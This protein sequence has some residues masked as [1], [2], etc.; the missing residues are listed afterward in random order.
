MTRQP[1]RRTG[2]ALGSLAATMMALAGCADVSDTGARTPTTGSESGSAAISES[3][4]ATTT[5]V[6]PTATDEP[7]P[8]QA[9]GSPSAPS[10]SKTTELPST[11]SLPAPST[12]ATPPPGQGGDSRPERARKSRIPA[13]ALPGFNDE[14]VWQ[15]A[16]SGPG[17]GQHLPGLCLQS[18]LTAIGAVA[19]HRTDFVSDLADTEAAVQ[20]TAVLP[21]EQTARTASDVLLTWQ[22]DCA[23][24]ARSGLGLKRVKVG[25]PAETPTDVGVGVH[26]LSTYGPVE[27][28]P[29]AAWFV[30]EGFVADGDTMT[31]LVMTSVGQDYN[32]PPGRTPIELS[33]QAAAH[34]LIKSR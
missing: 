18:P 14:W 17:P 33:L 19:E 22:R 11:S 1:T 32:Y 29:N 27:G 21:D 5:P 23:T 30:A 13:A 15:Q 20:L 25:G 24:H 9:T 8:T 2:Y 3:V 6:D 26:W 16:D 12:A 4:P 7:T 31:Y 28:D 34:A 10:D